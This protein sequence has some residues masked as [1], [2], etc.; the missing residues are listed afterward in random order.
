MTSES[1][2]R[3]RIAQPLQAAQI[4][5]ALLKL[6]T[7]QDLSGLGKTSLYA[8]IKAGD[9]AVIRLG[10]RCT[11]VTGAEAQ[12]FLQSLAKEGAV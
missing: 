6:Q 7:V 1:K 12:R 8:R 3:S 11:R 4:S 5:E 10:K 9:L 2:V